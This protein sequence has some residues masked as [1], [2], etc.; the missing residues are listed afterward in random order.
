MGLW[1]VYGLKSPSDVGFR[2]V[3][4]TT[5]GTAHRLHQHLGDA[6]RKANTR[7]VVNWIN[8]VGADTVEIVV[9]EE[10]PVGDKAYLSYAER[11]WIASLKELGHSL[12][13]HSL[14]GEGTSG[15]V[16]REE[17]KK[18]LSESRKHSGVAKGER[19]PRYGIKG[20]LHPMFGMKG[21]DHPG[22]GYR[23]TPERIEQ[24]RVS[25]TGRTHMPEVRARISEAHRGKPK[26]E[27]TKLKLKKS[28]HLFH[29]VNRDIISER[30]CF[31]IPATVSE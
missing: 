9:L 13:N 17:S 2:Y 12:T 31:C 1:V 21:S 7:H 23:D 15:Y 6:R 30:C 20:E 22:F 14:G 10:C 27:E 11:Y 8:S 16:M 24:K 26:S 29:H 18:R 3:G 5:W 25:A 19:N 4:K 28:A